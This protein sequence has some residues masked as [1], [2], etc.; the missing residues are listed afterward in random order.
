VILTLSKLRAL[1]A[2]RAIIRTDSQVIAGHI[3]K[4]FRTKEPE[5]HKYL[6]LVQKIKAFSLSITTKSI[7]R[8]KNKKSMS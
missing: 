3:E 6:Q 7:P 1:S 8:S 5:L 4:N 2:R